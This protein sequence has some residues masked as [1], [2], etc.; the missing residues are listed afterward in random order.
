MEVDV[1]AV[2][3]ISDRL[4]EIVRNSIAIV[5]NIIAALVFIAIVFVIRAIA[6]S[7]ADRLLRRWKTM[8]PALS[9][10]LKTLLS[11]VILTIG[12]LITATIAIPG[13]TATGLL[14]S[15]GVGSLAIGLAFRDTFE[16]FLAGLLILM[17]KPMRIGDF[18]ECDDVTG[19][20]EKITLRDSYVRR[21]DGVLVLVPN[22]YIFKNPTRVLTDLGVRRN[23]VIVGVAYGEDVDKARDVIETAFDG[24]DTVETSRPVE[25][26]AREFNSSSIDFQVTWWCGSTPLEMRQSRDRVVAAI[27]RGLDE[28]GIEIPFPYRTLTFKEPLSVA[29]AETLERSA[30]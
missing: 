4:E 26:F 20:V 18:I 7:I 14:T 5:P 12:F 29:N 28:A 3:V 24:L 25:V 15:L 13:L 1:S 6:L 8:R 2:Q 10:A 11:V 30:A 21:T 9:A 23:E 19:K 27:K 17:R 16:N 22:S